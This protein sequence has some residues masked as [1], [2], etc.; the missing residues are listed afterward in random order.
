MSPVESPGPWFENAAHGQRSRLLILPSET[1]GAHFSIEYINQPFAG[2]FAV[3]AH[4]HPTATETFEVL[5]GRARYR[6]G[7][8]EGAAGPGETIVM[9]ANVVHVHPWSDSAES[10]HVRQAAVLD[11]PNLHGANAS[12]QGLITI[13][14]LASDGK[15]NTKGLPNPLQLAVIAAAAMPATFVAGPPIWLQRVLLSSVAAVG[16]AVGYRAAYERYG[17]LSDRGFSRDH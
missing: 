11:P 8:R 14:G 5:A 3:P 10:L 6:V 12:L 2:Q 13:C 1:G 17:I 7:D 16:R 9:P 4:L 15:V